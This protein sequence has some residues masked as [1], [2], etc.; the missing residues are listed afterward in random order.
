MIVKDSMRQKLEHLEG[1]CEELKINSLKSAT[2][3][4]G[5]AKSI[6]GNVNSSIFLVRDETM[7]EGYDGRIPTNAL[8]SRLS[9][10]QFYK[11]LIR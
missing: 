1:Y 5:R 6:D 11:T 2:R 10:K 7:V 4:K 8:Q 3:T 9:M